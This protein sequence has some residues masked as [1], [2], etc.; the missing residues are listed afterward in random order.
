MDTV[1]FF[2]EGLNNLAAFHFL[3]SLK[4]TIRRSWALHSTLSSY[5][6]YINAVSY[7]KQWLPQSIIDL[8]TNPGAFY[9]CVVS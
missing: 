9:D 2:N 5:Q 7:H 4:K 3:E 6:F 8:S 1:I